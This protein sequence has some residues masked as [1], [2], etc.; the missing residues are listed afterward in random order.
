MGK[1]VITNASPMRIE[2][3]EKPI[4]NIHHDENDEDI[5]CFTVSPIE[6]DDKVPFDFD[7]N[8]NLTINAMLWEK[9]H[10][11]GLTLGA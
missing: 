9:G 8:S 2:A 1:P 6:E 11:L 10:F 4:I 5:W 7:P 3:V